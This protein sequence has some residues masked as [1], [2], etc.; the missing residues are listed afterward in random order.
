M[1]QQKSSPAW[2]WIAVIGGLY[3]AYSTGYSNG[4]KSASPDT[5]HFAADY[6][7]D[8]YELAPEV[9]PAEGA[10]LAIHDTSAASDNAAIEAA[11]AATEAAELTALATRSSYAAYQTEYPAESEPGRQTDAAAF[12][13]HSIALTGTGTAEADFAAYESALSG[14]A[15]DTSPADTYEPRTAALRPLPTPSPA[16][17]PQVGCAENGSCYGDVSAA[18]GRP[19]TVAVKGY[20][21]KDG[22]YVRG[23]YRSR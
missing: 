15:Y 2:K 6:A 23:H 20:F 12:D 17:V 5:L 14:S 18:T 3:L 7:S 21:R 11:H 4:E 19:K 1:S 22:T 13:S 10:A 8:R 16:Y 9:P